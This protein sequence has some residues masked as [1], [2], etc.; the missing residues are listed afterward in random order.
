MQ[1]REEGPAQSLHRGDLGRVHIDQFDEGEGPANDFFLQGSFPPGQKIIVPP[2]LLVLQGPPDEFFV[3]S[4]LE[5]LLSGRVG[6]NVV[7]GLTQLVQHMHFFFQEEIVVDFEVLNCS[8][9]FVDHRGYFWLQTLLEVLALDA[10]DFAHHLTD[11]VS[12]GIHFG[13]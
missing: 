10:I 8:R 5:P 9:E 11:D 7:D 12:E 4:Y 2:S 13:W 1:P 3:E 6:G